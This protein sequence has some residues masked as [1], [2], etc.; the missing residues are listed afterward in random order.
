L[1]ISAQKSEPVFKVDI[2]SP[3]KDKPQCKLWYTAKTWWAL[4]PGRESAS[5]WQRTETGWKEQSYLK[6]QLKL[7]NGYADVWPE[8]NS[9]H[10][11]LVTDSTLTV[12]ALKYDE[13]QK[14]WVLEQ[15][16]KLLFTEKKGM[17]ETAT[18][19]RDGAG[20]YWVAADSG[21]QI[22]VWYTEQNSWTG[23]QQVA[24]GISDDDISALAVTSKSVL[25]VW[26]DQ[27]ADAVTYRE[28]VDSEATDNWSA[29][30]FIEKGN[31]TA[32]DHL[33]AV[34]D[35]DGRVYIATKNSLDLVGEPQLVLRV[36]DLNGKW[37]NFPYAKRDSLEEPSR[38]VVVLGS[39]G[40]KMFAGHT[41]YHRTDHSKGYIAFGKI[42]TS[43]PG[44]LTE[45]RKVIQ[46]PA[47]YKVRVNDVT[48]PRHPFPSDGPWII[49]A[50]DTEGR[51]Y[52]ADL[53]KLMN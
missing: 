10:A 34:T 5:L 24:S 49:L 53:R 52:E 39:D 43:K 28:H 1:Y 19:V 51:V 8:D 18:I 32:D 12:V 36:R 15:T 31:H 37:N 6:E 14:T 48:V 13:K 4:M 41:I 40:E 42:D 47:N 44:I 20:R 30:R 50:S 7:I 29:T 26:S 27:V 46:P 22:L 16:A 17:I 23:P 35:K 3:T 9:I 11:V 33:H 38:P 2:A 25:V 45:V 21:K